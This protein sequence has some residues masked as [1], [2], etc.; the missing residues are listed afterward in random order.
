E[1]GIRDGH[2]TGVQTCA[3]PISKADHP[4]AAGGKRVISF[5]ARHV[6]PLIA[7]TMEY[8]AVV[9][10]CAG[11]ATPLGAQLAGLQ[12]ASGTM[13]HSMRSEERRVGK[14]HRARGCP[15]R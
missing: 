3:L 12:G 7:P 15:D 8:S 14:E 13:P 5:G 10:G 2:V 1:D 9:G 4:L 6:H 11:C